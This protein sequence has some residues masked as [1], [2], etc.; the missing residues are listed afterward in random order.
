MESSA[1]LIARLAASSASFTAFTMLLYTVAAFRGSAAS[2]LVL[3]N[4]L[5]LN[6]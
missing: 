2:A 4:S 5:Q 6:A 1:A 3:L